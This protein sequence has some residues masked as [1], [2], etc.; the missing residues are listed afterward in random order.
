PGQRR[1]QRVPRGVPGQLAAA[2]DV[3][4]AGLDGLAVGHRRLLPDEGCRYMDGP[5]PASSSAPPPPGRRH[6][7][8]ATR[9]GR[10]M[11]S[12]CDRVG[13]H[14]G[15][16]SPYE[17]LLRLLSLLQARREWSGP[18]LCER[19]GVSARTVRRDIRRLRD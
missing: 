14:T 3:E 9:P 6:P 2:V 1:D 19:L 18:A 8:A 15:G 5:A 4:I 7:G 11:R 12:G 10:E 17:R 13:A 16:V